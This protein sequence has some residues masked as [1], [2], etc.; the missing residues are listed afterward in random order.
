MVHSAT[1]LRLLL[2]VHRPTQLLP[3]PLLLMACECW[4]VTLTGLL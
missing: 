3:L 4:G 1:H 2:L